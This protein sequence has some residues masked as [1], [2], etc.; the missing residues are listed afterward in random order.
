MTPTSSS[1]ESRHGRRGVKL[2]LPGGYPW[3]LAIVCAS[4]FI[5]AKVGLEFA[6]ANQSVTSIWAPTGLAL[7]AVLIWGYRMWPAIAAGA[8][9]ANI[10]TA[11]SALSVIG[12][13]TGNTLEALAG[14]YL[15]GRFGDFRPSLER[16]R[17]VVSLVLFAA[18]ISTMI[19]A[20]VGVASLAASGLV[21]H[22]E[23]P[24]TW[25]VWWLGDLGGDLLVAP[26]LLVLASRIRLEQRTWI[27]AEA[28]ALLAVLVGISTIAFTTR[29]PIAYV[30]FPLLFWT[31]FRFR[32]PGTVVAG[33]IVSGIAVW[34]TAHGSGPFIGGSPDAELLRSQMFV[35]VATL[36]GL[37]A[38]A[39]ITERKHADEQLQYLA[40]HDPLTGLFNRRR[41]T[42][43]LEKWTA[44]AS[45]YG[46]PGALLVVDVDHFKNVNDGLGHATGDEV[47]TRLG[48]ILSV[49][50]RETDI[51]SRWG[52]DEFTLLLPAT[53][54]EEA[55][56]VATA[57][58]DGVGKDRWVT[59]DGHE[60]GVTVSIGVSRFGED[61]ELDAQQVLANADIAMYQA[62]MAGRNRVAV[63]RPSPRHATIA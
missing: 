39:L 11:G 52:G 23:I 34:F 9:L 14:A 53:S 16:I 43:E 26:A 17:D 33:L 47:I 56:T 45:R 55:L 30:I 29:E 8:F 27:G 20:T 49:R 25:R 22:G 36:T 57:L 1:D 54:E 21:P 40:D 13:S 41:F 32:Q 58:L 10:T 18:I 31:A 48:R 59:G 51:V 3:R 38:A 6:F 50:L 60:M 63:A 46:A 2:R 37:L 42:E 61:P 4:Y 7:A 35:G 62:K 19:S 15:L 44:Y 12:I 5:S 24:S 28:A